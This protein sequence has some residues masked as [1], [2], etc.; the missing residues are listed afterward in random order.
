MSH[1]LEVVYRDNA[2]RLFQL[3]WLILRDAALAE[4][5]VH[6]AF[7]QLARLTEPPESQ[8]AYVY[9]CVRN[10][11]I[12]ERRRRG[13]RAT[14][15]LIGNEPSSGNLNDECRLLLEEMLLSLS[16]S[17]RDVIELR[18]RLDFTFA[19]IAEM[20]GEPLSTVSS[21][22]QR[23]IKVLRQRAEVNHE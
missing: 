2:E 5:A 10:A 14:E 4:D 21:R 11:A 12:D 15:P 13:R 17:Q 9:R 23:A 6:V 22:Y 7:V 18:L 1:W 16:E 20:L 19:E 8:S 3:A